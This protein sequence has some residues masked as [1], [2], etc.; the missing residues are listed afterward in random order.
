MP[1][2]SYETHRWTYRAV[3]TKRLRAVIRR[4][5]NAQANSASLSASV[6][7]FTSQQMLLLLLL[8]QKLLTASCRQRVATCRT[9]DTPGGTALGCCR[10]R[11]AAPCR[12]PGLSKGVV[13]SLGFYS[14]SALLA[15]QSAVT[16]ARGIPSVCPSVCP[17][18]LPSR[19][20]I[21]SRRM[22]IRSCGF[23][24]LVGQSF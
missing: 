18:V 16:I 2:C 20:G 9:R 21:V 5:W 14:A 6:P 17:S 13:K 7:W 24:R 19:S 3:L 10:T 12:Q 4:R 22:K 1:N 8:M 15:M 11:G 23:Q